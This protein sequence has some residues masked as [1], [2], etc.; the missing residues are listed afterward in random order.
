VGKERRGLCL[1]GGVGKNGEGKRWAG[2]KRIGPT[3]R[4]LKIAFTIFKLNFLFSK[5]FRIQT[6]FEI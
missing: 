4:V 3:D 6:K 1:V 5:L 2:S